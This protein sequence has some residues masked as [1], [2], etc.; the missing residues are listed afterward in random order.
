MPKQN[1]NYV[2]REGKG[3]AIGGVAALCQTPGLDH[4]L[5]LR[6]ALDG[7]CAYFHSHF[8]KEESMAQL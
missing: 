1:K 4:S 5:I 8:I 2:A 6:T 3:R 7:G